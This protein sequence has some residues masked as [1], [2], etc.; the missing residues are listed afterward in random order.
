L[1]SVFNYRFWGELGLYLSSQQGEWR[2]FD[3]AF[4]SPFSQVLFVWHCCKEIAARVP[5]PGVER[6]FA[7][8]MPRLSGFFSLPISLSRK[9]RDYHAIMRRVDTKVGV[10]LQAFA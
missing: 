3:V 7:L 6:A 9:I 10:C 4:F 5:L 1:G 8:L 2:G